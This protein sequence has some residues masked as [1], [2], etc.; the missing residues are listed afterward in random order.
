[1][2]ADFYK[3]IIRMLFEAM[4][5]LVDCAWVSMASRRPHDNFIGIW[6]F[7]SMLRVFIAE[8]R[9]FQAYQRFLIPNLTP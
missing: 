1:M 5:S 4:W 8:V 3:G 6:L 7:K 9:G 2:L